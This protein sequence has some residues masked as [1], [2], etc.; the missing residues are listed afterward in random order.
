MQLR[1]SLLSSTVPPLQFGAPTIVEHHSQPNNKQGKDLSFSCVPIPN[2]PQLLMMV[3]QELNYNALRS[4]EFPCRPSSWYT[5]VCW[6]LYA[7]YTS[8][9]GKLCQNGHSK[10]ITR[11]GS[12]SFVVSRRSVIR[13]LLQILA[14]C[15]KLQSTETL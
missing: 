15:Y 9:N 7:W 10:L 11:N 13:V 5:I 1:I 2:S 6:N 4:S 3:H 12:N 14:Y 8:R